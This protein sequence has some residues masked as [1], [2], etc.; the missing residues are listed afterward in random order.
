[1]SDMVTVR[2]LHSSIAGEAPPNGCDK[3]PK[4]HPGKRESPRL[5][6]RTASGPW[7]LPDM[8][9]GNGLRHGGWLA[10]LRG[11]RPALLA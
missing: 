9:T 7:P 5:K 1:M 2:A 4:G 11:P 6:A 10:R 8:G 3:P